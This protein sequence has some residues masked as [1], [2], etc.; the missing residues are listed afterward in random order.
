M[1]QSLLQALAQL[2]PGRAPL[3]LL[4]AIASASGTVA[5]AQPQ[6][7][8]TACGRALDGNGKALAGVELRL[9][10]EIGSSASAL[11]E[12]NSNADGRFAFGPQAWCLNEFG[13]GW[14]TLSGTGL[15]PRALRWP[16]TQ[17]IDLGDVRLE[18]ATMLRVVVWRETGGRVPHAKVRCTLEGLPLVGCE[19]LLTFQAETDASGVATFDCVGAGTWRVEAAADLDGPRLG[20][21][22]VTLHARSASP[23]PLALYDPEAVKV[24][25]VQLAAQRATVVTSRELSLASAR[26]A[27]V[28]G[29]LPPGLGDTQFRT[30]M[31]MAWGDW[32]EGK[33]ERAEA[34]W[35]LPETT[36]AVFSNQRGSRNP[37][38]VVSETSRRVELELASLATVLVRAVPDGAG[39]RPRIEKLRLD[40]DDNDAEIYCAPTH[41]DC[42]SFRESVERVRDSEWLVSFADSGA[43]RVMATLDSGVS[44]WTSFYARHERQVEVEVR[45]RAAERLGALRGTARDESGAPVADARVTLWGEHLGAE[46]S[47]V[48]DADGAYGFRD[49]PGTHC[50]VRA[51]T[52]TLTTFGRLAGDF[53]APRATAKVDLRL[54]ARGFQVEL[55]RRGEPVRSGYRLLYVSNRASGLVAPAE[56]GTFHVNPSVGFECRL[57]LVPE[58]TPT[59]LDLSALVHP[60]AAGANFV[61]APQRQSLVLEVPR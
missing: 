33:G 54:S 8:P 5:L 21:T 51:E 7:A 53:V 11:A 27:A 34:C 52:E 32:G 26:R 56:D 41:H 22:S 30:A 24:A 19:G 28:S 17:R 12:A 49:L 3:A 6:Q 57:A 45:P 60:D 50:L 55:R 1:F 47:T 39:R 36:L 18:P 31:G 9:F 2:V 43:W 61:Q 23:D 20:A 35:L 14:V 58:G 48:T 44:E 16:M 42:D 40:R 4:I 29:A 25:N 59:L 38:V 13:A 37:T 15:A 46:R 10:H